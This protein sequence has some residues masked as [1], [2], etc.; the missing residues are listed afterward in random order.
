MAALALVVLLLYGGAL[1]NWWAFD[2]TQILKHAIGYAPHEYFFVPA[3]WRA[4]I[5]YS[6]TPWLTLSYDIDQT[7]FGFNPLGFY[8]HNLLSIGL[9]AW[10]IYL[11]A[12][13][14]VTATFALG[15]ALVFLVGSPIAVASQQLMV[16]HY[17]EGLL[18]FL[19]AVSLFIR[20]VRDNR[21]RLG[22]AAGIA[23][24]V[25]ATAKEVFLPLGLVP[26]LLP[27][28]A[29]RQ[30]LALAWPFLLV[31]LL[32]V[33]W[34][35]YMLGE[36]VGGYSPAGELFSGNFSLALYRQLVQIPDLMLTPFGAWLVAGIALA[37]VV[38]AWGR[39]RESPG[40]LLLL[41]IVPALLLAP[42]TPLALSSGLASERFFV[43]A[44]AGLALGSAAVLGN[45]ASDRR[46][47]WLALLM[48]ASLAMTAWTRAERALAVMTPLQAEYFAQGAEIAS[49]EKGDIVFLSPGLLA[50][51]PLGLIDLRAAMGRTD[52]PPL[53]IADEVELI[54]IPLA[55]R[56]V[57][58][59][60]AASRTMLD[61]TARLP[62]LL[63]Q[64]CERLRPL[65][66]SVE[67]TFDG[68]AKSLHWQLAPP[69]SGSYV[70]LTQA[71][72]TPV[73]P[74]GALRMANWPDE[75]FRFRHDSPDGSIAY[76]P[77]LSLPAASDHG[78]SRLSWQG[79]GEK[80]AGTHDESTC[81][82]QD[83]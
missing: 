57:L 61:I 17:I 45:V 39:R 44:W 12:R 8:A 1:N 23:F 9:C 54:G 49:A 75:K 63:A 20:A 62:K 38:L 7:L 4:L 41:L 13:Q 42:L 52:P 43:A 58:R 71:S 78:V 3:A 53:L 55:G 56:R 32:Y 79:N 82:S 34:R 31:M 2:D 48:L 35:W 40:A 28:G 80:F 51:Y 47:R 18:F 72:R 25:S 15:G 19:V 21:A 30:R 22:W 74:Q 70:F 33:P 67:M 65:P 76:T 50:H 5:A 16:R 10:M 60:D 81:G 26:F 11:I 36:V 83:R 77:L 24:A 6:L 29:F 73:P 14:W 69:I 68:V 46:I 66:L 27:V 59:Y 64:W 37:G